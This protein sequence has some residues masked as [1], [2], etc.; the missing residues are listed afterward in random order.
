MPR[1]RCATVGVGVRWLQLA[2]LYLPH[3]A[4]GETVYAVRVVLLAQAGT[5]EPGKG[6]VHAGTGLS[7][8]GLDEVVRR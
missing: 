8:K 4:L 1:L 2:A 3:N 6:L 7:E 5:E